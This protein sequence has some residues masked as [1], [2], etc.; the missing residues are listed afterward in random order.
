MIL[1]MC[2]NLN[3]LDISQ[4]D[5]VVFVDAESSNLMRR[6]LPELRVLR[7]V[8][9][10]DVHVNNADGESHSRFFSVISF[11]SADD[12]TF[13]FRH[14]V[15]STKRSSFGNIEYLLNHCPQLEIVFLADSLPDTAFD[16]MLA[17]KSQFS[18]YF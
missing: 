2:S 15:L 4:S 9:V 8:G 6:A 7:A 5:F 17:L 14:I 18:Y 12:G 10:L 11:I 16:L 1:Q 3:T 13:P